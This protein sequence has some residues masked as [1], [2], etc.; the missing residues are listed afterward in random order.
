MRG[1]PGAESFVAAWD[2]ARGIFGTPRKLTF[3]EVREWALNGPFVVR[4]RRGRYAGAAR[5]PN[6]SAQIRVLAPY[7]RRRFAAAERGQ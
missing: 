2:A 1:L 5:E 3:A 6:V 4:L 7:Y